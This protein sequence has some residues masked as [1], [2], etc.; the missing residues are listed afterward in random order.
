MSD[1]IISDKA[2]IPHRKPDRLSILWR[3]SFP[4]LTAIA[5][6]SIFI[7][8]LKL[9]TPIYVLQLL[10]RVIASRSIETLLMLSVIVL[11]AIICGALLE[12]TRRK[13]FT[14]WGNWIE[15][16]FG[17]TLFTSGMLKDDRSSSDSSASLR[18]VSTLRSF[19]SSQ[20]LIAWLD[21]PWALLFTGCVFLISPILGYI[22]LVASL[23]ALIMGA[24]NEYLTR[25]SRNATRR[26]GEDARDWVSTAERERET[27]GSLKM[28]NSFV[29][30]WSDDAITRQDENIRSRTVHINFSVGMRLVGQFVRIGMLG[31]GIWLVINEMLSL[32]AVVAANILGRIAYTLVRNALVKWRD[33]VRA[34]KAYG[35]IKRSLANERALV[36]SRSSTTGPMPLTM[37]KVTYRYPGQPR[38]IL[39]KIDLIINPGELLCVVG[40]SASGKSTFCRLASGVLIPG[41]GNIHLGEVDVFRLQHHSLHRGIGYLPQD[42]TL[43]Q[44]TVRENIATMEQGDLDQ[45]IRAAKLVG[46]H[47]TIV[48]LPKGYDTEIS[49]REPL[50]S[51]GQRKCIA[52]ARA[53]YGSPQLVILDEP[54][55]HLDYRTKRALVKGI[56]AL[57]AEGVIVILTAQRQFSAR[58]ANKALLLSHGKI[59]YL[60]SKEEIARH[61]EERRVGSSGRKGRKRRKQSPSNEPEEGDVNL[62]NGVIRP[63]FGDDG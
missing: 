26:A 33:V 54:F 17:P 5:L 21:L 20:S 11:F 12:V 39:Q 50:L 24:L 44:G 57:V 60:A 19:V 32:G 27:V 23:L 14:H 42:I 13:L 29:K 61:L 6:F 43:F 3:R 18:D 58:R 38:S 51:A 8:L 28:I 59:T 10:D 40:A 47:D 36:V 15:R 30:R 1:A 35:R 53:F 34:R 63:K 52:V 2:N 48:N 46:V 49:D 55:P 9:A 16:N 22:V 37:Q 56:K 25:E 7:N 45:V 62:S 4:G 41:S 31:V